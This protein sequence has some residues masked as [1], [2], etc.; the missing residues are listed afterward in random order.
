VV[1]SF[2]FSN[3]MLQK[4]SRFKFHASYENT[5]FRNNVVEKSNLNGISPLSG[6]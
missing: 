2:L 6:Q 3:A 4:Q 5:L 1:I